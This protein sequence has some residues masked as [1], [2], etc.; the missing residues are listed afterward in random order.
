M[1]EKAEAKESEKKKIILSDIEQ[2]QKIWKQLH[3]MREEYITEEKKK[4]NTDVYKLGKID[5]IPPPKKDD[6]ISQ[7]EK[8]KERSRSKSKSPNRNVAFSSKAEQQYAEFQMPERNYSGK[9]SRMLN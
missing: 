6:V 1:A 5:M 3:D 9:V 2:E 7:F 4:G 8:K